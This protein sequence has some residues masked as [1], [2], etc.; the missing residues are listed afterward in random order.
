MCRTR[1]L[2]LVDE[3][4]FPSPTAKIQ[5]MISL[6]SVLVSTNHK[7]FPNLED[8]E[9][10]M[11]KITNMIEIEVEVEV[12]IKTMIEIEVMV[13]VIMIEIEVM[14]ETMVEVIVKVAIMVVEVD[15]ER[16]LG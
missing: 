2:V 1:N 15:L 13:E 12:L 4:N 11:M 14:V 16:M 9:V 5:L 10:A 8:L 3:R 7:I 6:I